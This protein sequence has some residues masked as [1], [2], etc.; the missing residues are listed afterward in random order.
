MLNSKQRAELR[1]M[2]NSLELRVPFLDKK[3][4]ELAQTIP[5]NCRVN[6]VTTKLALRKAAEKMVC[7]AHSYQYRHTHHT[8]IS[9][10]QL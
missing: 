8:H 5:L 2:A 9:I 7:R 6:T 1:G 3:V 10:N 4:M